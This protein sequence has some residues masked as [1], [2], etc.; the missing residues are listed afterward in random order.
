VLLRS[1]AF[2]VRACRKLLP[3]LAV[4]C[5][6]ALAFYTL[7][8]GHQAYRLLTMADDP[9]ALSDDALASAFDAEH[10]RTETEA[11][12]AANDPDLAKSFVDLAA[13]RHVALE[14]AL[15]AR[16]DAAVSEVSSMRHR[17]K[18]FASGFIT[19]RPDD[20]ASLA[21]TAAGDLFV[22]GDIRDAAREGGRWAAGGEPDKLVLGL[23][24]AGLA[25]TA[26]TY[27]TAGLAAPVRAGLSVIKAARRTGRLGGNLVRLIRAERAGRIV[28]L[29]RDVG[30]IET[31]AGTKAAL[32]SVRIA[33]TP[34]EVGRIAKLAEKEGS[35]TRAILKVLGRGAIM[36]T[37]GAFELALWLF[38]AAITL[39]SFVWSLKRGV[40]RLT[41]RYLARRKQSRMR[42]ALAA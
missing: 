24:S 29:A 19:G 21:G 37:M 25:I 13:D 40:E 20:G 22:F 33:E 2:F 27:A 26:A 15:I 10:A 6:A 38:G 28:A 32:E 31:K 35:R 14:P 7:P 3:W 42:L 9:V 41:E 4:A 39:L 18:S 34:A 1:V 8:R 30:K 5:L 12:L 17:L 16:V 11:A 36:L 23:A